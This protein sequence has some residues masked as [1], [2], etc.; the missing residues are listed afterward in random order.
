MYDFKS[1]FLPFVVYS[2]HVHF[3]QITDIKYV[4]FLWL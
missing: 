2:T 1:P 4:T 3:V